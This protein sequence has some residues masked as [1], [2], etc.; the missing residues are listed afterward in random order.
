MQENVQE[1][2][3]VPEI[4]VEKELITPPNGE[5]DINNMVTP[6]MKCEL[7]SVALRKCTP[8]IPKGSV[9]ENELEVPPAE[10]FSDEELESDDDFEND[11]SRPRLF[12]ICSSEDNFIQ[13]EDNR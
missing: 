3:Q 1:K 9:K 2:V 7:K 8:W 10:V 13:F 5:N 6:E 4:S 11:D 12:S